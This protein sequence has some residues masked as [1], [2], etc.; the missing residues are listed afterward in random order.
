MSLS[1]HRTCRQEVWGDV[2]VARLTTLVR[3]AWCVAGAGWSTLREGHMIDAG[4]VARIRQLYYAEHWKVGTIAAEL[5]LH[6]ETVKRALTDTPRSAPPP[7]PSPVDPYQEFIE[8]TLRKHPRLRATRLFQMIRVRGYSGSVRQLRR[9]VAIVRPVYKEAFLRLRSFRGEQ[10]QVDWAHFGRVRVGGTER[11]LSGFVMTLSHSRA[12]YLE[13]FFDQTLASFLRGHVRAFAFFGGVCRTLLYDNLRSAVLERHGEG[14]HFHPRLLELCAH[15]H[16]APRPCAPGRGNEKG[17]VE[18]AIRYIR[19]SFFAARNFTTLDDFNAQAWRWRDEVAHTRPWPDDPK[20]TVADAFEQE[21]PYLVELARH[22]FD[23]DEVIPVRSRQ[24]IYVSFDGNQYSIPRAGVGRPLTLIASD[25]LVRILDGEKELVHHRRSYERRRRIEVEAHILELLAE[26][27]RARGSVASQRLL[28]AAPE[29]EAFLEAAFA[30]GES[31][32]AQTGR[33]LE[34][35]DRYGAQE[36]CA[37]ITEALKSKTERASSV[38][39]LLERR[40]RASKARLLPPV[41]LTRRPDLAEFH[42]QPHSAETY[43][44]LSSQ[45]DEPESD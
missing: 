36:L 33:L 10:A 26:K 11:K 43:D 8:Q 6:A 17:R 3:P 16:C 20:I 18:R 31:A 27:R 13:F 15:Y 25:R 45:S 2:A 21:R 44:E 37:A 12:L 38:A 9:R 19:D 40:R 29:S 23:T 34:L 28:T 39:Y 24:T 14:V 5:G 30:R 22:P 7:R 42:V 35:L 41:D 32:A 4:L 1:A